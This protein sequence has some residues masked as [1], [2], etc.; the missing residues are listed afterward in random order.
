M[1]VRILFLLLFLCSL[2][3]ITAD[4][5]PLNKK[6]I[7]YSF[8]FTNLDNF[9]E[10]VFIAYPINYS[11]GVPM[12]DYKVLGQD[13]AVGFPCKFGGPSVYAVKRS[14]FNPADIYGSDV[15]DQNEKHRLM[16]AYFETNRNLIKG[17]EIECSSLVDSRSKAARR[18]DKYSVKSVSKDSLVIEPK[19][20]IY[21]DRD[22]KVIEEQEHG[23]ID[24]KS[25]ATNT[26]SVRDDV[27]NVKKQTMNYL[28]FVIP[29]IALA[30]IITIVVLRRKKK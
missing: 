5:L 1:K 26:L 18:L 3:S 19:K 6:N 13:T 9:A 29:A 14:E 8:E 22:N 30:G 23:S 17:G 4:E 11:S 16:K 2:S 12:L 20:T 7:S 24:S 10:Y 27:V 28:I 15:K 25:P 21:Y